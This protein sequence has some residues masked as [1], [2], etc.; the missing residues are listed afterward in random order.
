MGKTY[1]K[2]VSYFFRRPRGKLWAIVNGTRPK[3]IPPDEWDDDLLCRSA[4]QPWT[5]ARRMVSA[6]IPREAAIRRLAR[7]FGMEY[8]E[9]EK[10]VDWTI[11]HPRR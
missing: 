9:A 5:V 7:K 8:V 4:R 2:C 10:I 1:K 3:A 11:K 6:K